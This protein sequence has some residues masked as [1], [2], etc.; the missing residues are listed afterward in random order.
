MAWV[1]RLAL[2]E[3]IDSEALFSDSMIA[4]CWLTSEKLRLLLFHRNR[5]LQVR[6]GTDLENVYHVRSEYNPADLGTRP[7]KVRISDVGPDSRWENG[8]TWMGL[9]IQE[10][11]SQGFIKPVSELRV[12]Q[13]IENEFNEGL[14]YGDREELLTRGHPAHQVNIVSETRVKKIQERAEFSNYILLP[15]KYSFPATVR[16]YGY[17]L[18]F[19]KNARKG[20]KLLGDLLKQPSFGFQ[21]SM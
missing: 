16:I 2:Q 13:E 1:V 11:V 18:C 9:D 14:I 5:V 3:W 4:L 21:P 10:A 17:V 12:S 8:D 15:T 7:A 20:K 19:V 6:R